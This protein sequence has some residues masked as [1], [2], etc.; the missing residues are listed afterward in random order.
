MLS[1]RLLPRSERPGG[2]SV[3]VTAQFGTGSQPLDAQ[4]PSRST[5]CLTTLHEPW[6][7]PRA[8]AKSSHEAQGGQ[9]QQRCSGVLSQA[10]GDVEMPGQSEGVDRQ[11]AQAAKVRRSVAGANLAVVFAKDDVADP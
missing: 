6:V 2:R 11:G 5:A 3:E 9:R 4:H 1:T 10:G 8:S 7:D